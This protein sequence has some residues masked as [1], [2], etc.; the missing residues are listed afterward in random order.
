MCSRRSANKKRH[1]YKEL[2]ASF[3]PKSVSNPK[4]VS[5]W[6]RDIGGGIPL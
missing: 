1:K 4:S 2:L 6:N 5:K 3:S